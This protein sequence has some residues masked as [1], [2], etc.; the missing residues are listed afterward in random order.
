MMIDID[1]EKYRKFIAREANKIRMEPY[2]K[3]KISYKDLHDDL[4][5][6]L[7]SLISFSIIV[8]AIISIYLSVA[9]L[10]SR[11]FGEDTISNSELGILN[12]AIYSFGLGLLM[13]ALI[14]STYAKD[15]VRKKC[16]FEFNKAIIEFNNENKNS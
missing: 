5:K 2:F 7:I 3:E 11:Y 1:D 6:N 14:T 12:L 15:K 10:F 16:N 13:M 8:P 9:T 4:Q